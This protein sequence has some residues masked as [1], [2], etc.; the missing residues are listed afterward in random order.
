MHRSERSQPALGETATLA[1]AQLS[2]YAGLS[3]TP[4]TVIAADAPAMEALLEGG[5]SALDHVLAPWLGHAGQITPFTLRSLALLSALNG[6]SCGWIAAEMESQYI[7]G[8]CV[9]RGNLPH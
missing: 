3:D 5:W 1:V 2:R 8:V 9:P 4:D 6:Q 7:T